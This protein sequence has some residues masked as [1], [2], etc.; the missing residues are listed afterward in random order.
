VTE[1]GITG[2][3]KTGSARGR[4][5][6]APLISEKRVFSSVNRQ[7][8]GGIVDKKSRQQFGRS[9]KF[10]KSRMLTRAKKS[11]GARPMEAKGCWVR[12]KRETPV[13]QGG[14]PEKKKKAELSRVRVGTRRGKGKG[15]GVMKAA[16][17]EGRAR[18]VK[19][20]G[21]PH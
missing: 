20:M 18:G 2:V 9:E 1:G 14:I 13:R 19:K 8:G 4:T 17:R 5:F 3:N 12:I 6:G 16:A 7:L 21:R 15:G 11:P 10:W